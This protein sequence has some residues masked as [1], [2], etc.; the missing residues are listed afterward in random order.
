MSKIIEFN[1]LHIPLFSYMKIRVFLIFIFVLLSNLSV[2]AD[3]PSDADIIQGA[4]LRVIGDVNVT[5]IRT[6]AFPHQNPGSGRVSVAGEAILNSST[7][8]PD[9][10][11]IKNDLQKIFPNKQDKEFFIGKTKFNINNFREYYASENQAGKEFNFQME[12]NY[13]ENVNGYTFD[14]ISLVKGF[15]GVFVSQLPRGAITYDSENYRKQITSAEQFRSQVISS[16]SNIIDQVTVILGKNYNGL[17]TNPILDL[18]KLSY[19]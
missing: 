14:L 2:R 19:N 15:E 8:L 13:F 7:Y 4:I 16:R 17:Y 18:G 11:K 10:K 3:S 9:D 6:K 12:L 1:N 5:S